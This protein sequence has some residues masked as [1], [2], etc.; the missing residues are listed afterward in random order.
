MNYSAASV[1]YI[2]QQKGKISDESPIGTALLGKKKGDVVTVETPG[3]SFELKI[4]EISK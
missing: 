2:S 3:G 4:L 1:I